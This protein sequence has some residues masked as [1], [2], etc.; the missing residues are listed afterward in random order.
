MRHTQERGKSVCLSVA[1]KYK[2]RKF[3]Y[4]RNCREDRGGMLYSELQNG[5]DLVFFY[6]NENY[7]I[8][9]WDLICVDNE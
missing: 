7:D 9:L 4:Y 5:S 3:Y 8:V 2:T 6:A 1:R